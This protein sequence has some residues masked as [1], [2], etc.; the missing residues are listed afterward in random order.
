MIDNISDILDKDFYDIDAGKIYANM[1]NR[2]EKIV[3]TKAL[4]RSCGNQVEASKILGLHRNTLHSKI[5]KFN[6]DIMKFKK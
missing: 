2:V 6:I 4:E 1:V 3:I 5:K